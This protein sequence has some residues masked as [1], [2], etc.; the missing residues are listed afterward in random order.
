MKTYKLPVENV[1]G[2]TIGDIYVDINISFRP[3]T[4]PI[5]MERIAIDKFNSQ[6]G[7]IS[8]EIKKDVVDKLEKLL[9]D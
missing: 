1:I 3:M 7:S 4:I 8:W 6:L 5:E 9:E 2:F